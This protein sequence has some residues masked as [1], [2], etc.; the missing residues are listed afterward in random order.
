M[1]SSVAKA[2]AI[3]SG[4]SAGMSLASAKASAFSSG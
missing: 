4:N 3:S 2:H 1:A